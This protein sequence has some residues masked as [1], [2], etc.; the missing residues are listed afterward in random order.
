MRFELW[1]VYLLAS[2]LASLTP[3][4]AVLLSVSTGLAQGFGRA[5][6]TILGILFANVLYLAGAGLGMGAIL[7]AS[8][9]LF[10]AIR[11]AGA[12]YLV[13]LGVRTLLAHGSRLEIGAAR[14]E[15]STGRL[16]GEGFLLQVTNP[17]AYVYVTAILPQFVEIDR[18]LLPQMLVIAVTSLGA[19]LLVLGGYAALGGRARRM[20]LGER[21]VGWAN[22]GA[23]AVLIV[24]G[25]MVVA[26]DWL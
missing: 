25:L 14:T 8:T 5:L 12:A 16:I 26:I 18:P 3:G 10:V 24:A 11:W 23:G 2:L 17:K 9:E 1:S 19:E 20:T 22:R 15:R 7:A 21:F 13:W 4:P 6:W